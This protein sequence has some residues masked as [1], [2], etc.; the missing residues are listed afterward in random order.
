MLH[1]IPILFQQGL[2]AG[3]V[4]ERKP[5]GEPGVTVKILSKDS[6]GWCS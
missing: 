1:I 5:E 4:A 2:G 6:R 3:M